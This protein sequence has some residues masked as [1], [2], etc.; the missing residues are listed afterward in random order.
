M[1]T[2]SEPGVEHRDP[3]ADVRCHRA[4]RIVD[5]RTVKRRAIRLLRA[6]D[7]GDAELSILLCDDE[8]IQ[9]LN[10]DYRDVD[11]PTDVLAFP[12]SDEHDPKETPRAIGDVVISTETA[13]RQARERGRRPIDEVT[14]LLIHGLLHLLGHDHRRARERAEMADLTANLELA[15]HARSSRR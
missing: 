10:R 7:Q 15:I 3:A 5:P 9:Q 4:G 1:S 2:R 13:A 11:R 6:V 12:L 8:T 14:T